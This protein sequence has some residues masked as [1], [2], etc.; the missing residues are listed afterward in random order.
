MYL[1][2]R[3]EEVVPWGIASFDHFYG[4][5]PGKIFNLLR[6]C[7]SDVG[8]VSV[9]HFLRTG[10]ELDQRVT[11][12]CFDHPS[13]LLAR[14]NGLGFSFDDEIV[15]E[16]FIYL[17]YKSDFS[18]SLSLLS[19][20]GQM[21]SEVRKLSGDSSRI[22]F[23]NADVLF[24]LETYLLA[25]SSAE[26]IMTSFDCP[27]CVVLGCYQAADI[28]AHRHLDEVGRALLGSYLEIKSAANA[29]ERRYELIIHKSP[30]FESQEKIGLSMMP[31]TGFNAPNIE[32]ITH[33]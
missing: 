23:L 18:H 4:G 9:G 16:Q 11:L 20:Y 31:G 27:D 1:I 8:L 26:R 6:V 2:N 28:T 13:Y 32:L 21:F 3:A 33:G 29:D 15:S 19:N 24:N 22:A 12:I 14:L 30:L 7:N 10:I 25:E 5:L 17:H